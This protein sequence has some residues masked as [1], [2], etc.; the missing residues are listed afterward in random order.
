M[1]MDEQKRTASVYQSAKGK[2]KNGGEAS[3]CSIFVF[4]MI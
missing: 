3:F 4:K 1:D 2:G